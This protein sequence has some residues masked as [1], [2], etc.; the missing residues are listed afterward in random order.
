MKTIDYARILQCPLF[1][2]FDEKLFV[3]LIN[4][5]NCRIEKYPAHYTIR[6]QGTKYEDLLIILEGKASAKFLEFSGKSMLVET[7]EAPQAVAG[8]VLFS[9]DAYLP[10]TLEAE[11]D[12]EL[13]VIKKQGL[14]KIFQSDQDVLDT[15]LQ[16]M[17]DKVVFLAEKVRLAGLADLRQKIADY[18]L[19]NRSK[20]RSNT[21]QLPFSRETMAEMFSVARPSLLV[22]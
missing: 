5:I 8:A 12:I 3:T 22:R 10:V 20:F 17:G 14:L 18:L 19:R 13:A 4:D 21:L 15:Y 16:D 9:S 11:T 7:L 6:Q 2:G 1:K